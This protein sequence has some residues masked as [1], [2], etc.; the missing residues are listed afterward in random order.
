[1]LLQLVASCKYEFFTINNIGNI[2]LVNCI[3]KYYYLNQVLSYK[4]V[5]LINLLS[6]IKQLSETNKVT[7]IT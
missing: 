7:N 2:I 4:Y 3:S 5:P 6:L 1:M